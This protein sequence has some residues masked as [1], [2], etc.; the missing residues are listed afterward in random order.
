MMSPVPV[1]SFLE[2]V[3]NAQDFYQHLYLFDGHHGYAPTFLYANTK[4]QSFHCVVGSDHEAS[5]TDYPPTPVE[6]YLESALQST[7]VSR[8]MGERRLDCWWRL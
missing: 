3:F 6:A 4:D 2:M 5:Y 7:G 8:S 1:V